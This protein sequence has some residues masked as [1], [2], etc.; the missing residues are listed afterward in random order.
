MYDAEQIHIKMTCQS[1]LVCISTEP[2]ECEIIDRVLLVA[3]RL[4]WLHACNE[5]TSTSNT[6]WDPPSC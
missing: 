4:V 2:I 1:G 6:G 5:F 3:S